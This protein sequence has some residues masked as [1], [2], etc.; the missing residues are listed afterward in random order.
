MT[1]HGKN[2]TAASVYTYHERRRDA[3]A[4]GYGTL[5]ARLGADSIKEFHCCSLTL[6]PCR[7]P[8][9]SPTGYIF[10]REAILE[11]ILAQK[12]AYAKKLKEYEKQVAEESA[13]A[14]IAE[15]QA[16]TFTKRTQFSAIESTPSRTGAVATPRPE[17]GSLKRQGGVMSTEIAAKVKAHGEEGVMS[18]MKGDKST[19]LP[20]FWI[21]ELN[22]TAVATKLEKPSSK[23]LCPVSGKPIK[24]KELLE[25]KFTPMPGT[26][27]AAHRKF[28]C[29]V[30]RDE[31]T[32][33]TRCAYL[34]KS[35]SVVKYDV[36]EKLI[37]GDGIDPIN[38]EPMSEDDI[39]E[40]QRG[41]TGY[42]ATNETKAKLI[43]PQLELQ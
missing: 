42:S 34:K 39:I 1:R 27:T 31:L 28:L 18:N 41:G 10:D 23:V 25:V 35:K 24:L 29:P 14:K 8:V 37:K 30:T 16:E 13:A 5:H 7:N 12:K 2:S 11:N 38:G 19:S 17:V 40:L 32:N 15:G 6:Q 20:S 9:I 26:E 43:R 21:P 3:K 33:T 22:P 36:V 4:S